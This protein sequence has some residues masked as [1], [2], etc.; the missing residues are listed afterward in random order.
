VKRHASLEGGDAE[1]AQAR[2]D[3]KTRVQLDRQLFIECGR[4]RER[5]AG[6][7]I[8]NERG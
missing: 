8:A 3:R 5:G 2:L 6:P 7:K 1:D 4:A